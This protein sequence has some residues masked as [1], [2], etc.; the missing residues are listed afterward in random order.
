MGL[1]FAGLAF[2]AFAAPFAVQMIVLG[3]GFGGLHI[4]FGFL[5]ARDAHGHES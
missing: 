1:C 3:L 5:I 2:G 4:L